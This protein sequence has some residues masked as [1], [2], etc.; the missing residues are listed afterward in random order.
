MDTKDYQ[1]T[2]FYEDIIYGGSKPAIKLLLETPTSKEVRI[3][4][5]AG[6]VMAEHKSPFSIL[7][8]ILKGEIT[9]GIQGQ[10]QQMKAGQLI[11]LGP[12]VP[13]DLTAIADTIVRLTIHKNDRLDRVENII[14]N[15]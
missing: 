3:C 4:I 10:Q 2:S 12:H 13:H 6:Q 8:H 5:A 7:I 9:L 11:S 15:N 1:S 14:N